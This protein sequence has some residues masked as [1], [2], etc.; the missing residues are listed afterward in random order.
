VGELQGKVE[1]KDVEVSQ[2]KMRV[3]EMERDERELGKLVDELKVE[4]A[5]MKR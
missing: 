4:L 2:W 5:L 3:G 1:G